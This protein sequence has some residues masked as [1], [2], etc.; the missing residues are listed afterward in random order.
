MYRAHSKFVLYGM[1]AAYCAFQY[2]LGRPVSTQGNCCHGVLNKVYRDTSKK[3]KKT[4]GVTSRKAL[5]IQ[6]FTSYLKVTN[7][8]MSMSMSNHRPTFHSTESAQFRLEMPW[9]PN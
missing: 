9:P 7:M 1:F 8:S 4:Y 5:F 3:G 2:A 6:L